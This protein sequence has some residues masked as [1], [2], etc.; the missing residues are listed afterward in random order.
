MT[1]KKF[2]IK[3]SQLQTSGT[4]NH[5]YSDSEEVSKYHCM[6]HVYQQPFV[7]MEIQRYYICNKHEEDFNRNTENSNHFITTNFN[8]NINTETTDVKFTDTLP[9]SSKLN[10]KMISNR[11]SDVQK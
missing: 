4:L 9:S 8:T 7:E 5:K 10:N 11:V 2:E 3:G 6:H 1:M